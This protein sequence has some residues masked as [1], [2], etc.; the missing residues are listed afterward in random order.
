MLQQKKKHADQELDQVRDLFLYD[1]FNE[2]S[3]KKK[4]R[5]TLEQAKIQYPKLF[6]LPSK[7]V[8]LN[9]EIEALAKL[10]PA[11]ASDCFEISLSSAPIKAPKEIP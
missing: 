11:G 9:P 3:E 2:K 6:K 8:F 5:L 1:F 4:E 7:V 10:K